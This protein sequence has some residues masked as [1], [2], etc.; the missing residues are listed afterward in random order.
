[1]SLEYL[2]EGCER[3]QKRCDETGPHRGMEKRVKRIKSRLPGAEKDKS[4]RGS[5][6]NAFQVVNGGGV[7][8]SAADR[9][10]QVS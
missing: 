9:W 2:E 7:A 6:G 10:A 8:L 3:Q 5:G 1:V 4:C